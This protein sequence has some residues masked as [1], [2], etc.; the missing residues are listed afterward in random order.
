[1]PVNYDLSNV[2]SAMRQQCTEDI[3]TIMEN[4]TCSQQVR[5]A[6]V[7]GM[8][9]AYYRMFSDA[10]QDGP[11]VEAPERHPLQANSVRVLSL[12][13]V[14]GDGRPIPVEARIVKVDEAEFEPGHPSP[15]LAIQLVSEQFAEANWDASLLIKGRDFHD[16]GQSLLEVVRSI[17]T[18]A[19]NRERREARRAGRRS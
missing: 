14:L 9:H 11:N 10:Q 16:I 19:R 18:E 5:D 13:G 1:M 8:L 6:Y 15:A 3:S 2:P 12:T 4:R 17:T 7:R